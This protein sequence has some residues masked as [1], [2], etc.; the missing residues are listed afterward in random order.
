MIVPEKCFGIIGRP[1]GHTLSPLLHNWAFDRLSLPY[2]Y[3]LWVIEPG[4]L[5]DFVSAARTLPIS[6]VSVTIPHKERIIPLIDGISEQARTIGAVNTLHWRDG[7]L[8]GENTDVAGF[9]Y[10]LRRLG[11]RFDSALVLGAGGAARA[12]LAGLEELGV[13]GVTLSNR[14]QERAEALASHFRARGCAIGVLAWEG[15]SRANADLIVNT[16]PLGMAGHPQNMSPLPPEMVE[17]RHVVYDLVYNPLETPLLAAASRRGATVISGVD[18]FVAQAAG[19]F[20]LWTGQELPM[21]P[22]REQVCG[23]L[24]G[25]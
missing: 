1:L 20:N 7:A 4:K 24:A 14:N 5:E 9:L 17:P 11:R 23:A 10:P 18:M 21:G 6:G 15:L 16:T 19:Q 25:M 22:A 2:T 12:V 13:R 8:L 3:H